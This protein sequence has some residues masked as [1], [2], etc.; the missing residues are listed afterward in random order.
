[1]KPT[2]LYSVLA[3]CFVAVASG[4]NSGA[5][6][7]EQTDTLPEP[8]LSVVDEQKPQLL[9][10]PDL[11]L[12]EVKGNV[13][14]IKGEGVPP[15]IFDENGTL[16]YYGYSEPMAKISHVKRNDDGEL[17]YFLG[18]EWTTVK[19]ENQ[20]PVS[21]IGQY[22]EDTTTHT[23]SYNADGLRNYVEVKYVN[24]AEE[25]TETHR[26][27]IEY[28]QN[29]FDEN[30]NWVKRIFTSDDANNNDSYEESRQIVYYPTTASK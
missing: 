9:D 21:I 24:E 15:A 26:Y 30:G 22:N 5:K 8:E 28:P 6:G 14:E 18:D 16:T 2:H 10:T 20:R 23:Y 7:N 19:W 1:M 13:K 3:C 11:R 29:A 25:T 12:L 27:R 17:V 4:C